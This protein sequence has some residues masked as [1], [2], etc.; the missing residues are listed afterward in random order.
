MSAANKEVVRRA[1]EEPWRDI[2]VL[3]EVVS[4][5]YVGFDPANPEPIRG[6]QGAKEN[7]SVYRS[8]FDGAQIT[9]QEQI[10]EGDLVASRWESHGTH[11]GEL[12]GIVPTGR[13]VVASGITF[14]RVRDG[15]IVEQYTNWD[16]LG[17]LQQLGVVPAIPAPS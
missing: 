12:M 5:E 14:S 11:T 6:A 9:I 10:A 2:D 1:I 7:V 13:E 15:K 8:A 17:M 4:D 3:D 16:T